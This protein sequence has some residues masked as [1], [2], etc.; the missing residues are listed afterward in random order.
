MSDFLKVKIRT[1]DGIVI[2]GVFTFE[3]TIDTNLMQDA[4]KKSEVFYKLRDAL[5][6]RLE[7]LFKQ[8]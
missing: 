1:N 2:E 5:D 4:I 7:E 6:E 8:F 3:G